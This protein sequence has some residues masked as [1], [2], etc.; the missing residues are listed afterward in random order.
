MNRP[1]AVK[2][3][4]YVAALSPAQQLDE[5]T[6]DAWLDVL[7]DIDYPLAKRAA[8]EVAKRQPFVDPAAIRATITAM[9]VALKPDI[10]R[11]HE[12]AHGAYPADPN[13]DY[14]AWC[15][16][17][18]QQINA[19]TDHAITAGQADWDGQPIIAA[20]TRW[21]TPPAVTPTVEAPEL[22]DRRGHIRAIL[23]SGR[24]V[25]Q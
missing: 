3:C 16:H 6:P 1:E 21:Y 22:V 13:T 17:R 11:A 2:L 24:G 23:A 15:R 10:R 20:T 9:R 18:N 5:H 14:P 8:T 19:H 25:D 4:R 7:A 12:T